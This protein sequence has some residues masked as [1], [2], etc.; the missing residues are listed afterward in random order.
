MSVVFVCGV[1]A[2]EYE[3]IYDKPQPERWCFGERKRRTGRVI[4]K[5]PS[6]EYLKRTEAWGWA[7]PIYQY[8]CDGC[9]DDR[10]FGFGGYAVWDYEE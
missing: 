5:R 6:W 4:G 3:V 9:G 2:S 1:P 8:V 7:E 10:R